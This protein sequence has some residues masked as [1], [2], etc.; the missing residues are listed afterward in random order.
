MYL[1]CTGM[2]SDDGATCGVRVV[3]R[4]W[5]REPTREPMRRCSWKRLDRGFFFVQAYPH[6]G[7]LLQALSLYDYL[8]VV[9]LKRKGKVTA[10]QGEVEFDSVWP[11]SQTWVQVL[12]EP[13]KHAIVCLDG[14]LSMDFSED[15]ELYRRYVQQTPVSD[16]CRNGS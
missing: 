5:T 9:K 3:R 10:T 6:R 12:R 13:G 2:S 16:G 8:S 14:Y 15:G 4:V 1:L 11:L 7:R